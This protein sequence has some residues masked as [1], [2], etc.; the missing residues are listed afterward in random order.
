MVGGLLVVIKALLGREAK[1]NEQ[2]ILE[3]A[4]TMK[5]IQKSMSTAAK[6]M[7]RWM[8]RTDER[9]LVLETEHRLINGTHPVVQ[10]RRKPMTD[11]SYSEP[12]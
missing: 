9:L 12:M 10:E 4:I 1:R 2:V 8:E 3:L 5:S 7:R 6:D 11:P